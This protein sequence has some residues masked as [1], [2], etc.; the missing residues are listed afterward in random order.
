MVLTALLLYF[1]RVGYQVAV[2]PGSNR[3]TST[4]PGSLLDPSRV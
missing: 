2:V 4:V 1:L 3:N